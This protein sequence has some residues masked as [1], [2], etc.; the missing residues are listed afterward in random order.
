MFSKIISAVLL[1]GG[2]LAWAESGISPEVITHL[3]QA[4]QQGSADN[5]TNLGAMYYS[6]DGV[7]R[8]RQQ[9]FRLF[10]QACKGGD[11]VGCANLA[12]MY[13]L[14]ETVSADRARARQ[15]YRQACEGGVNTGCQAIERLQGTRR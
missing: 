5:C 15:L 12:R 2:T 14:G 13:E 3:Q 6:G 1:A 7:T 8:D 4:C 9:A 11:M 10:E